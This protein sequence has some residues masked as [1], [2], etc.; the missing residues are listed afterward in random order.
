MPKLH[1]RAFRP[2]LCPKF[3]PCGLVFTEDRN[4]S[5]IFQGFTSGI[6]LAC[7]LSMTKT[8]VRSRN[9]GKTNMT[10]F[11]IILAL[12]AGCSDSE[13]TIEVLQDEGFTDIQTTGVKPFSCGKD[14]TYCTG[15][16]AAGPTGRHV[17]GAVGCGLGWGKGC[18]VRVT[19]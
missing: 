3:T 12:F 9:P 4:G 14:D 1:G 7:F 18:T 19:R 8:S 2:K 6:A 5:T 11:A 13:R 16:E 15:F 17:H 10:K